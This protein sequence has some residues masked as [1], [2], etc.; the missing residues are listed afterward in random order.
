MR[1]KQKEGSSVGKIIGIK[2]D[3]RVVIS[4]GHL[5][6]VKE[7][8][9]IYNGGK[10]TQ[11]LK[12]ISMVQAFGSPEM[13]ALDDAGI[14][15]TEK[16][17]YWGDFDDSGYAA[18]RNI[19]QVKLKKIEKTIGKLKEYDAKDV[20]GT[21]TPVGPL[22]KVQTMPAE[23]MCIIKLGNGDRYLV[24]TTQARTYIRMWQKI[25]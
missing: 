4:T 14:Q 2:G 7:L 5:D 20:Y 22:V 23:N 25:V 18:K 8:V 19:H 10:S 3:K 16:P 15:L 17:S 13:A 12:P 6:L 11:S 24:D 1:L 21:A 9:K